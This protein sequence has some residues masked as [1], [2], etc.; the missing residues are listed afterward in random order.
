MSLYPNYES[1]IFSHYVSIIRES[2]I[3]VSNSAT[4]YAEKV[5]VKSKHPLN[6]LYEK[7][8]PECRSIKFNSNFSWSAE[9]AILDILERNG[10][11][12]L[13]RNQKIIYKGT[14]YHPDAVIIN[15][16]S[17]NKPNYLIE[18]KSSRV[19]NWNAH[20]CLIMRGALQSLRNA[21][22]FVKAGIVN[23]IL[24]KL[25]V[26]TYIPVDKIQP[27]EKQIRIILKHVNIYRVGW[28]EIFKVDEQLADEIY[29]IIGG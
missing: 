26:A 16:P 23:E 13:K 18:V 24:P 8:L 14:P 9:N 12:G 15:Q 7:F 11:R 1:P 2:T 6:C 29:S 17:S 25:V 3:K 4:Y 22:V 21:S 20:R 27:E 5:W 28:K 10:Y 19:K